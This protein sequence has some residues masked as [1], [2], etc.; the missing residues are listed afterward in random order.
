MAI[1]AL[2]SVLRGATG[3]E[4]QFTGDFHAYW[5]Q[6]GI[7]P[8]QFAE[9]MAA[10]KALPQNAAWIDATEDADAADVVGGLWRNSEPGVWYDASDISTMYQD[11]AGTLPVYMPGSGQVDPPVGLWLDKRKGLVRGPERLVNGD[12]SGGGTSWVVLN[13]DATHVVTFSGGT[14]RFQCDTLTPALQVQQISVM[15]VGK[16]YEITVVVSGYGGGSIKTD[17]VMVGGLGFVLANG[18]GTYR[19]IGVAM[20]SVFAFTRAA[21]NTD[22]TIDSISVRE[23]PGN[24]AYQTTTTSRPTLSARYNLFTATE[25]ANGLADAPSRAGVVTPASLPGYA[26]ALAFGYDGINPSYAYKAGAPAST[27][28]TLSVVVRMDDGLP[29]LFDATSGASNSDFALV[30]RNAAAAPRSYQVTN[31]G[32]GFY[33]VSV[34]VI[35]GA[36]SDSSGVVKYASNSSRRFKVTAYDLRVANDGVGLPPYQRV[37]DPNTYDT[38]EFPP[39]LKFDGVDDWLQT[40]SVDFSGT[41]K[42][43]ATAALRKLS[44][45]AAGI[46]AELSSVSNTS[47]GS[48]ALL[49]PAGP[50]DTFAVYMRG[51]TALTTSVPSGIP[52]PASRVFTGVMDTSAAVGRQS[53]S[54]LNGAHYAYASQDSGGGNFGGYPLY[55]GRRGGTGLPFNGRLYSLLIRGVA[56][57]DSL[58][59]KAEAYLNQKARIY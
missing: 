20:S 30:I 23:L 54:R 48:F 42:L 33:R 58:I 32:N 45:S 50:G 39:Y 46:V 17:N 11:A 28:V 2:Q 43:F 6:L 22:I 1:N 8:G 47:N 27:N 57:P 24:H 51:A 36:G 31:L 12:F 52:S 15:T 13:A 56:T 41:D 53:R 10:W 35:S 26:G 34:A 4:L 16:W 5:D 37:V 59:A 3:K 55:I 38:V 14:L 18:Q 44:D 7:P 29:P 40:A 9:R 21:A 49:A 25:F 19:T